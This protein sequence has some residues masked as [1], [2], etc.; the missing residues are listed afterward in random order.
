M[1]VR[2]KRDFSFV[3]IS[4]KGEFVLKHLKHWSLEAKNFLHVVSWAT[5]NV[6]KMVRG[7]LAALNESAYHVCF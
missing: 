1:V 5:L 2:A 4:F 7:S 6:I 3:K